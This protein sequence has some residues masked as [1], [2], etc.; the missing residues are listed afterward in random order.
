MCE[1]TFR[2]LDHWISNSSPYPLVHAAYTFLI[3]F[4]CELLKLVNVKKKKKSIRLEIKGL[5]DLSTLSHS[6]SIRSG[7]AH[8]C[9]QI[10]LLA[11]AN[12]Y[13]RLQGNKVENSLRMH[14]GPVHKKRL[15]NHSDIGR[16]G[17]WNFVCC[18]RG[19]CHR[20]PVQRT[21]LYCD[22]RRR[23]WLGYELYLQCHQKR[24]I[25]PQS[26]RITAQVNYIYI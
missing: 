17:C 19:C 8:M 10:R 15:C 26:E 6:P 3:S 25:Q 4:A 21:L 1:G 11:L 23:W 24:E 22:M 7:R 9:T 5:S 12:Q 2:T 20:W 16:K 18:Y 13:S 14:Q